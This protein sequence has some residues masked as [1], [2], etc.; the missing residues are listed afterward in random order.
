MRLQLGT[1][2][3]GMGREGLGGREERE[4]GLLSQLLAE[5]MVAHPMWSLSRPEDPI[6]AGLTALPAVIPLH[7]L[8]PLD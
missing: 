4:E 2:G 3:L 8:I 6:T 7:H 5:E 1:E